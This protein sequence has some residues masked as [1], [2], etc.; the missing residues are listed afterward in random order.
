M[1]RNFRPA[2]N[3]GSVIAS[4]SGPDKVPQMFPD[5]ARRCG[6]QYSPS[7]FRALPLTGINLT[8]T[9]RRLKGDSALVLQPDSISS[10][11]LDPSQVPAIRRY[12]GA[13]RLSDLDRPGYIRLDSARGLAGCSLTERM[14]RCESTLLIAAQAPCLLPRSFFSFL[15]HFPN[16]F[17]SPV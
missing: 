13:S 17:F 4:C 12:G 1:D 14:V 2:K 3:S 5:R 16:G 11:S 8:K 9:E 15:V 6:T 7:R 10:N